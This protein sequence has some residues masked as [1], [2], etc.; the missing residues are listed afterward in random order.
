MFS[1]AMLFVVSLL[2]ILAFNISLYDRIKQE[3]NDHIQATANRYRASA[4]AGGSGMVVNK[5]TGRIENSLSVSDL[6]KR[7]SMLEKISPYAIAFKAAS[8]FF[9]RMMLL[10]ILIWVLIAFFAF[11]FSNNVL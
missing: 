11:I 1:I 8:I 4:R 10:N 3:L 2:L 9:F 6:E 7:V 5:K